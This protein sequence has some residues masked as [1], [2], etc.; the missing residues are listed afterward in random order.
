MDEASSTPVGAYVATQVHVIVSRR[1]DV[2]SNGP[3]AVHATRVA[4]RRLRSSLRTFHALWRSRHRTVLAELRWYGQLLGA[5]RD[6]EVL[7]EAMLE[8]LA[9]LE[10]PGVAPLE[11]RLRARL[12]ADRD[13]GL[14]HLVDEANEARYAA[15]ADRLVRLVDEPDWDDLAAVP[16]QRLLAAL[17]YGPVVQVALRAGRLP[18][19]GPDRYVAMHELRKKAKAARYAYEAIGA[20]GELE[21]AAWKRVTESLG[22]VQDVQVGSALL[23]EL[24]QAATCAGEPTEAYDAMRD[25]LT[26]RMERAEREGLDALARAIAEAP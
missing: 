14:A 25:H 7:E 17:A 19:S 4:C 22:T 8:I 6:A 24:H 10:E 18:E 12:E 1:A 20:S 26:D 11:R 16:A 23:D 13:A 21:A 3:D 9:E 5:P 2:L 15:L